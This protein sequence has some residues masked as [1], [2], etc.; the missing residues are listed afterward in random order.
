[1]QQHFHARGRAN[2]PF[3]IVSQPQSCNMGP[4]GLLGFGF[5]T[6]LL[7]VSPPPGVHTRGPWRCSSYC[8]H[9]YQ[10]TRH[11]FLRK[12]AALI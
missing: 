7:Q 1:M 8:P 4:L 6:V 9:C 2:S 10:T 3:Y 5:T 11:A 12:T